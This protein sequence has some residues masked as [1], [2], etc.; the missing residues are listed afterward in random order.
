MPNP[1]GISSETCIKVTSPMGQL[2][3]SYMKIEK[4]NHL[5]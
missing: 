4:L 5:T 1:I 3:T 2:K